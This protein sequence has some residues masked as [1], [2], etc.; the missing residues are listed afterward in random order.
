[1]PTGAL[2]GTSVSVQGVQHIL[3]TKRVTFTTPLQVLQS[4]GD[5]KEA[6][7]LVKS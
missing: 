3:N 7:S 2:E 6:M 1:M 4:L 5:E